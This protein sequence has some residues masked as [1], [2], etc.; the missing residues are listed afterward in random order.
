MR[1]LKSSESKPFVQVTDGIVVRLERHIGT[2]ETRWVPSTSHLPR[3]LCPLDGLQLLSHG[4]S[5]GLIQY[6][7][8]LNSAALQ[9][10]R[11]T[12]GWGSL[13][14]PQGRTSAT[15]D[16][17]IRP[18]TYAPNSNCAG[19]LQRH[20]PQNTDLFQRSICFIRST[21]A[22]A[23]EVARCTDKILVKQVWGPDCRSSEPT[24]TPTGLVP[25]I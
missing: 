3:C 18:G 6:V 4:T 20:Y 19:S 5:P 2:Q 14:T 25:S 21:S 24:K 13:H 12:E 17:F 10:A 7:R 15:E 8:S 9:K 11:V 22:G 16:I 1:K 23:R